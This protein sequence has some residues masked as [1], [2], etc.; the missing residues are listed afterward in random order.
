MVV[1]L[2]VQDEVRRRPIALYDIQN[3][4]AVGSVVRAALCGD[5]DN[6]APYSAALTS[7]CQRAF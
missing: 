6:K 1:E 2:V 3:D 5:L 7:H 4:V